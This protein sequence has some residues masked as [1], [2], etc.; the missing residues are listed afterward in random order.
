MPKENPV[1]DYDSQPIAAR[2]PT[3]LRLVVLLFMLPALVGPFV[4]YAQA[5]SPEIRSLVGELVDMA[6][7]SSSYIET[8]FGLLL[9]SPFVFAGIPLVLYQFRMLN[10]GKLSKTEIVIGYVLAG[11][12]ML[13]VVPILLVIA[14][15]FIMN[16]LGYEDIS[17]LLGYGVAFAAPTV[18]IVFGVL[19]FWFL[20]KRISPS[21][22][23]CACMCVSYGTFLLLAALAVGTELGFSN[24]RIGYALSLP[25]IAGALIELTTL[26]V[27]AFHRRSV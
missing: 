21:T 1:L 27:L 5:K 18:V 2:F 7:Y 12:Y 13:P 20:G 17:Y 6:T 16:D 9:F 19:V 23:A 25:V 22:R 24:L 14:A 3:V 4:P 15:G 26:G 11:L 8:F 10:F